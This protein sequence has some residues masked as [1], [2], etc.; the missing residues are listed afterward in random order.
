MTNEKASFFAGRQNDRKI[1]RTRRILRVASHSCGYIAD[2]KENEVVSSTVDKIK[3][4]NLSV[5]V[6]SC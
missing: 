2:G 4:P 1:K 5:R 3:N 6:W